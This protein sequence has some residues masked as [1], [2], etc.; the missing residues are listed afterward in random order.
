VAASDAASVRD[1]VGEPDSL[2]AVYWDVFKCKWCT[3]VLCFPGC[4]VDT[5]G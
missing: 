2:G 3:V 1:D 4:L 5:V